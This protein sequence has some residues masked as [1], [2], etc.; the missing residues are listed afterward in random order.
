M[1]NGYS[2]P[3]TSTSQFSNFKYKGVPDSF[4]KKM[5]IPSSFH[6]PASNE[7]SDRV[8]KI[9]NPAHCLPLL[10]HGRTRLAFKNNEVNTHF[11]DPISH[12]RPPPPL[13]LHGEFI[14]HLS[15]QYEVPFGHYSSA[16]NLMEKPPPP[17]FHPPPPPKFILGINQNDTSDKNL[18]CR[19]V[20]DSLP[21]LIHACEYDVNTC[22]YND[23]VMNEIRPSLNPD[24]RSQPQGASNSNS[25][26]SNIGNQDSNLNISEKRKHLCNI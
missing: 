1:D 6:N 15:N 18:A 3:T 10:P 24:V 17:S 23:N 5:P 16:N 4:Q 25:V 12:Q 13:Q 9:I 11:I 8:P 2:V 7:M 22:G 14:D 19:N 20:G 21:S 26:T